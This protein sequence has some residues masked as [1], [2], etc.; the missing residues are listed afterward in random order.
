MCTPPVARRGLRQR[1]CSM[2][3]RV[4]GDGFAEEKKKDLKQK[5]ERERELK[6][7]FGGM[8]CE[9]ERPLYVFI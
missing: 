5:R 8:T 7:K 6:W 9:E 3:T 2:I 1:S 4:S